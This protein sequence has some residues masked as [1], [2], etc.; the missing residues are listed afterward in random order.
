MAFNDA[1]EESVK[2]DSILGIE[3]YCYKFTAYSPIHE[4]VKLGCATLLCSPFRNTCADFELSGVAG[5]L[6]CCNHGSYCNSASL[7]TISSFLAIG[8]MI[9]AF[10]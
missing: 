10:L 8:L 7:T 1:R 4:M 3:Q 6:C 2:C 5:R 9:F